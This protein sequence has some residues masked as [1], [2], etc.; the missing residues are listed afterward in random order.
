MNPA[1]VARIAELVLAGASNAQ[2]AA[3]TGLSLR[4]VSRYRN[5]PATREAVERLRA[6][7]NSVR[8]TQILI[9]VMVSTKD[10][11]LKVDCARAILTHGVQRVD[12][13]PEPPADPPIAPEGFAIV[14]MDKLR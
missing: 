4:T 1:R 2:M 5:H 11:R 10:E 7:P 6:A 13:E 14:R 3:E 9:D 12:R 8:A